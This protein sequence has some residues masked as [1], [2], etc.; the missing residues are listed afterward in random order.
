MKT[1][2]VIL[3]VILGGTLFY[4]ASMTVPQQEVVNETIV[5]P[6]VTQPV[7]QE[8]H[9]WGY[10]CM[11][12]HKNVH[13]PMNGVPTDHP[14]DFAGHKDLDCVFCHSDYDHPQLCISCHEGHKILTE[15]K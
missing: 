8:T 6:V 7:P 3:I 15:M 10:E 12:C 5:E 9:V 4:F 14:G 2:Y 13:D 1:I 11:D